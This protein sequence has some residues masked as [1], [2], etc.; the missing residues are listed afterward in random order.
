[1]IARI[2]RFAPVIAFVCL[3]GKAHA[4]APAPSTAAI[5]TARELVQCG[6]VCADACHV[7]GILSLCGSSSIGIVAG[8]RLAI[9]AKRG[10]KCG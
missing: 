10:I 3:L 9:Q 4:E 7:E 5:A 2:V 8:P 6:P 1:M